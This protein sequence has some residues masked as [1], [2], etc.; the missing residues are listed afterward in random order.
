MTEILKE[1][2][3]LVFFKHKEFTAVIVSITRHIK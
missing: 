3:T 1:I 2:V